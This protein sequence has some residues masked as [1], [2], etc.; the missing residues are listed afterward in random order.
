MK[1]RNGI[2]IYL[3]IIAPF[4]GFSQGKDTAVVVHEFSLQQCVDYAAKNN[5]QVKNA[6]LDLK[7]QQQDNRVTTALALPSLNGSGSITDYIK[8]P[9]TLLPGEF[10]G[11]P[12][13]SYIPVKFGTK[14]NSNFAVSLQQIV[15]DGAVFVG[16][17]ARKT[18]IDYRQKN[19]DITAE[20]IRANVYKVYY[21]LV[22]SKTQMDQLDANIALTKDLLRV[23]NALNQNGFA[24]KLDV[25]RTTVQLANLE[26]EK[27]KVQTGID[28]GYLGLKLLMGM[29][30]QDSLV[31]TD[32]IT[33]E[34]IKEGALA[35][36][37]HSYGERNDYQALQ[38][39]Q[40]LSEYNIK[41]YRLSYLPTLS[42]SGNYSKQAQRTKFD[43]FGKG[44]WFTTSYVGLNLSIPIFDGF[45]KDANIRKAK[46]E[47]QQTQNQ[48]ENLKNSIDNEVLQAMNNFRTAINTINYQR[49]NMDLAQQ[50]YNQAQKKYEAGTGS[51]LEI[52]NAQTDLRVA[53]SNYVSALYDAIIAKVDFNKA[54]GK[55]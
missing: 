33:E 37:D 34:D 36:F 30:V 11:Q 40:K 9:T 4:V 46:F 8:I 55:L 28:N 53:Q 19:I 14:Y 21:Q 12:P 20:A 45:A 49:R 26:T 42:L 3:L 24:E 13:G 35:E 32:K 48:I 5:M 25:D 27:A 15:F 6:L 50:V 38:L 1:F 47:L 18:S 7:I 10:F 44:D 51:T 41:R 43:I 31:L 52:T 54:T 23:N 17:Q 16:L 2:I 29:P 39:V 22:V